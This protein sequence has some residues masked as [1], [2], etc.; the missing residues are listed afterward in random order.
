[1]VPAVYVRHYVSLA[2]GLFAIAWAD[3]E[4]LPEEAV[5]DFEFV[6]A[7]LALEREPEWSVPPELAVAFG[8]GVGGL[9]IEEGEGHLIFRTR[10]MLRD[11][12]WHP[13]DSNMYSFREAGR[14]AAREALDC[15]VEDR[16]PRP[17]GRAAKSAVLSSHQ[18]R[19][20]RVP[21]SVSGIR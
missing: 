13:A 7:E 20:T 2:C 8:D 18:M 21:P 5:D 16:P 17:V 9:L 15:L 4:P 14:L 12:I 6:V 11:A 19:Q 3:F 1:L 10:V